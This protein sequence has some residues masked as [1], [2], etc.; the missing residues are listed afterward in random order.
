VVAPVLPHRGTLVGPQPQI[1]AR[2]GR[3]DEREARLL[4]LLVVAPSVRVVKPPLE[5]PD[6]AR[7]VPALLARA[8]E[9]EPRP[10]GGVEDVLLGAGPHGAGASVGKLE[11]NGE[12]QGL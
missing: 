10:A 6:S 8:R 7:E 11:R 4:V 12:D 1:R 2:I 3:A 9:L 5:H